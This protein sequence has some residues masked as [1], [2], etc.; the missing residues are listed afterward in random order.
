MDKK[1]FIVT[2]HGWSASNW[3]AHSLNLHPDIIC[4]HSARNAL[5]GEKDLQ[6]NENL[7]IHLSQLHKGYAS[8]QERDIRISYDEIES[9]GKAL[10][11]GSV[12]LY[13]MRDV[14]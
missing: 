5:A 4:T 13:R 6:S 1:Y 3:V 2:S 12:H 10:Y 8:R 9:N 14:P 7:K 11:Y